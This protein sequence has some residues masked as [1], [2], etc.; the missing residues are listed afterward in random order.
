MNSLNLRQPVQ[1]LKKTSKDGE[2]LDKT[3]IIVMCNNGSP[4]K[5][6]ND[7]QHAIWHVEDNLLIGGE[8][9]CTSW[10]VS[11]GTCNNYLNRWSECS[12]CNI[13]YG[14]H[15]GNVTLIKSHCESKVLHTNVT[16][17]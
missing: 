1:P 9:D 6:F 14:T 8:T 16:V 15:P 3:K 10:L 7:Y 5:V 11:D 12:P 17:F 13:Y 4:T 2:V